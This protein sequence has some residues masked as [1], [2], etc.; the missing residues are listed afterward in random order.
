MDTVGT[1]KYVCIRIYYLFLEATFHY[2]ERI[3]ETVKEG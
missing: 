2:C 3:L 1:F